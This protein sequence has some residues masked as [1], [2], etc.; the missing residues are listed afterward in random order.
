VVKIWDGGGCKVGRLSEAQ[1]GNVS[2]AR[3]LKIGSLPI[4]AAAALWVR[5]QKPL[6]NGQMSNS[7]AKTVTEAQLSTKI[8]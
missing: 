5:I 4:A 7:N 3:Y 6:N 8:C 1:G 2:L